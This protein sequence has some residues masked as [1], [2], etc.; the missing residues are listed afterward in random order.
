[1][2]IPILSSTLST[3]ILRLSQSSSR[4]FNSIYIQSKET[5]MWHSPIPVAGRITKL[6][7]KPKLKHANNT[8]LKYV[9]RDVVHLTHLEVR[10]GTVTEV[11]TITANRHES[12]EVKIRTLRYNVFHCVYGLI[13]GQ[14]MF[15]WWNTS[16]SGKHAAVQW[17]QSCDTLRKYALEVAILWNCNSLYE[18]QPNIWTP[19]WLIWAHLRRTLC[20]KPIELW[21]IQLWFAKQKHFV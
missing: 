7:F 2:D 4:L 12:S 18:T 13:R 5:M 14:A 3:G 15:T 6:I 1:M 17:K 8:S 10:V 9:I 16:Q 20:N 19:Y 11:I 21:C